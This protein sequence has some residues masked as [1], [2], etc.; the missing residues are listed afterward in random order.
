MKIEILPKLVK[1]RGFIR[2]LSVLNNSPVKY[3]TKANFFKQIKRNKAYNDY[4]RIKDELLQYNLI[5][6]KEFLLDH[7]GKGYVPC[8]ALTHTGIY[9]ADLLEKI[10]GQ[11]KG[12]QN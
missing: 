3:L 12:E 10:E 8:I 5:E 11:L 7:M 6:L 2:V 1:K 4:Y 9:I